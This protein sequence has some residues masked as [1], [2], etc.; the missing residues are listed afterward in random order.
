M[1]G[2]NISRATK[3]NDAR[4]QAWLIQLIPNIYA[5][6]SLTLLYLSNIP[7]L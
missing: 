4:M 1:E 6:F 3:C 7:I 2:L 5:I